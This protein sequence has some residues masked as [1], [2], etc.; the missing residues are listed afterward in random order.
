VAALSLAEARVQLRIPG[1]TPLPPEVRQALSRDM[2]DHRGPE[3][4]ELIRDVTRRLKPFFQTETDLLILTASGTGA[5][6]AAVV[7]VLSPGDRVLAV[8]IGAFGDRFAEI[9]RIFGA[10][11]TPLN[12]EWGTAADPAAIADALRSGG[13]FKAV[14][15]THN[16][17]STGVTNDL[18]A[19]AQV[20]RGSGALLLVDGISSVGSIEI[21][22]DAWG[23]DV[24]LSGSQKGWMVPPGLA[25]VSVSP[26]AWAAYQEARLPRFYW[27]LGQAKRYLERGQTPATPAVSLFYAFQVALDLLEREGV[28][29]VFARHHRVASRIR[30]GIKDL[31]LELFA[32]GRH[33]S[34]TVTAVKAPPGLDVAR[35][36]AQLRG[37]GI[38]LS[39]GQGKLAGKIFR[40]GHLGFVD[41]ADAETILA[42]M[43][44][45]LTRTRAGVAGSGGG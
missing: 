2:I 26:R 3:F 10:D 18:S 43:E 29:N 28:A 14:L 32:D 19:I 15:L 7:N 30:A 27:D 13:P 11:V 16:E 33:A 44:R 17:T 6:E 41:D 40:I 38:V 4:A 34:D 1:P 21:K 37:D 23:C 5:L 12:F 42:G 9:A 20:V 24:V 8:S 31:G 35:L 25:L 45:A 39:G 36:L 22:T